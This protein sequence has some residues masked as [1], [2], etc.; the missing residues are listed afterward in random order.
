MASAAFGQPDCVLKKDADGI[1]IFA[2][3][4]DKSKFKSIKASFTADATLS[5]IS[6]MIM[7]IGNY[8][9]WQYNTSKANILKG[10]NDHTLIYYVEISA[11]RPV[12]N[13]DMVTQL[14]IRQDSLTKIVTV[15]TKGLPEYIAPKEGVIRVPVSAGKWTI[16]PAGPSK[17]NVVYEIQ[18]D[19]GGSVPTWMVNMVSAQAPYQ[20]FLNL[21]SQLGRHVKTGRAAFIID[22]E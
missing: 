16:T 20:S 1:K 15:Q 2:C 3:N 10:I 19:P 14:S 18:I 7:D 8:K 21:K 11:P 9:Q 17:V 6:D 12:N 4:S 5:Q 13:R 22:Q